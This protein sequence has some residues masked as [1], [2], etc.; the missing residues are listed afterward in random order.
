MYKTYLTIPIN[1]EIK[2]IYFMSHINIYKLVK[3]YWYWLSGHFCKNWSRAI[4]FDPNFIQDQKFLKT[5]LK[6]KP[7]FKL[8]KYYDCELVNNSPKLSLHFEEPSP[9]QKE[10]KSC[11]RHCSWQCALGSHLLE[12]L[13]C[14]QFPTIVT[15]LI[16]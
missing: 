5:T 1:F 4:A 13:L 9:L 8:Y 3:K 16:I 2:C 12:W 11:I 10:I 15:P 6:L 14:L 7:K